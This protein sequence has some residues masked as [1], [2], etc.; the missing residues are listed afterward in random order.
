ML[1]AFIGSKLFLRVNSSVGFKEVPS[2]SVVDISYASSTRRRGRI[3][4]G[5]CV[6]PTLTASG[7]KLVIVEYKPL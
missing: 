1:F 4:R 6:S 7:E 3:Q 5:G 2:G